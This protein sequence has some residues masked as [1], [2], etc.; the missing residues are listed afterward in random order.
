MPGHHRH[1][2]LVRYNDIALLLCGSAFT[3]GMAD[4][5][6]CPPPVFAT[7]K[8]VHVMSGIVTIMP[9]PPHVKPVKPKSARVMPTK[10]EPS[11]ARSVKP[12]PAQVTS[13]KPRSAHVTSTKLHFTHAMPAHAKPAAPGPAHAKPA[14]PGPAHTKP[15]APG[16]AHAKPAALG[17]A[18]AKPAL[19]EPVHKMAVIP[20]PVHKMAA[21]PK[22][23]HK[24]AAPS[25][26]P[27]KMAAMPEPHLSKIV[28]SK[29]HLPTSV[30]PKANQVM[31]DP[32]MSSQVRAAL[33]VLS[34]ATAEFP[35]P[36]QVTAAVPESS[37]VKAV[38]HESSQDTAVLHESSQDTAVVPHE[39]SQVTAVP[40][41]S[42]QV[43]AVVP[44]S[45]H[46]TAVVPESSQVTAVVPESSHVTAVVP[47]PNQATADLHESSQVTADLPES[48]QV[49]ADLPESRQVTADL[50]ESRQ[51]T[52]ALLIEP[53]HDMAAST[54][55]RQAT[56]V[57]PE[58][59]QVPSDLPKPRQVSADPLESRHV[60]ADPPEP[61]HV[62]ADPLEPCRV[63]ADP[64]EPRHISADPP[65]HCKCTPYLVCP[66]VSTRGLVCPRVCSRG[67]VCPRVCSRGLAC[68]RITPIPPEVSA[69]TVEPPKEVASNNELTAT[70]DHSVTPRHACF[71]GYFL[72]GGHLRRPKPNRTPQKVFQRA[73]EQIFTGFPCAIIVDDIIVGGKGE[74]EHDEN[75]RKVLNRARQNDQPI[76]YASRTLTETETRYAQ[77]E[78]ELLAV[79][80]ACQ[81][82]YDYIYGKPVL[83]ETDHQPLLTILNKPLHTALAQLRQMILKLHKFNLTLT[84]KKGKQLYLADTLSCAPRKVTT[85][86]LKDEEEFEV[87]A[88]QM[89]SVNRLEELKEHTGKDSSLQS[90]CNSIKHAYRVNIYRSCTKAMQELKRPNTEHTTAFFAMTQDIDNFMQYCSICNALKPHQQKEP[91]HI[92]EIPEL[93]W[94]VVAADIFDWNSQQYLV[95]VDSFSGWFEVN[96]LRN[97]SSQNIVNKLKRHFSVHGIPQKLVTDNGT[98][99]TSQIF[100]D[101]ASSWD[102]CHIT[103]SPEYSQVNE[104]DVQGNTY[105]QA[106]QQADA[107]AKIKGHCGMVRMQTTKG[108]DKIGIVRST[109]TEPRSY[110]VECDSKEY[111][112]NRRHLLPVTV[113]IQIQTVSRSDGHC[114]HLDPV[115]IQIRWWISTYCLECQQRPGQLD[116]PQKLIPSEDLVT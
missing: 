46:V 74:K 108:H 10:P 37:Q 96:P 6:P 70:S 82:F 40:H 13:T 107:E 114:S 93:P 77:I 47:E 25:E 30:A 94:S 83:V 71:M 44:E 34:Q 4:D 88:V 23:V 16:P 29:S 89:I 56:A 33:S 24:M 55:P 61:R 91:L 92:H 9:E 111:R 104:I 95:L 62:S 12:K 84:Y 65:E 14:A 8:N 51:D 5:Q 45:S 1:W 73:M 36:R 79:V 72:F 78:K 110:V 3:V 76:S 22:P 7:P 99:F 50:S 68:P 35:E 20:E 106:H 49:T 48:R 43:T 113:A 26:S 53:L 57:M 21:I 116:V 75:L 2:S 41:E 112:R 19:P 38:L 18:H 63:S 103:S 97:L 59:H 81:N 100:R 115:C 101:F 15:A 85:K 39:S 42:S 64:L 98:Q 52:A 32:L 27:V 87:M 28:S 11:H 86:D 80:F 90:L 54:E 31:A 102:F 60:S 17:P 105:Q 109:L 58:P 66:R 67:L 69:C